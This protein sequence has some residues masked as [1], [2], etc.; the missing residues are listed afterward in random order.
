M[1]TDANYRNR[2]S[3]SGQANSTFLK[4]TPDRKKSFPAQI[5]MNVLKYDHIF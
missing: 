3:V 1:Q 2:S 4:K 5:T